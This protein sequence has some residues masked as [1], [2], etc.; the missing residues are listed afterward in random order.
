MIL[1]QIHMHSLG[2]GYN[3]VTASCVVMVIQTETRCVCVFEIERD[4]RK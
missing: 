2:V 3:P 1:H 4:F